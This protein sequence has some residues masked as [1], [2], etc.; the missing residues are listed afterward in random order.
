LLDR[1]GFVLEDNANE[2]V[3][4]GVPYLWRNESS[5]EVV[6][7]KEQMIKELDLRR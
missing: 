5:I 6:G 3:D 2:Y 1:Y 7:Q 4:I